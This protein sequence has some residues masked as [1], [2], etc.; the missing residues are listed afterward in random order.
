M[1]RRC[2][3]SRRSQRCRCRLSPPSRRP[4]MPSPPP[5]KMRAPCAP[6]KRSSN[7]SKPPMSYAPSATLSRR[8]HAVRQDIGGRSL[9]ALVV[10]S[11]PNIV[12]LTNFTG[13]SAIV[14]VAPDRLYFITD[15]RYLTAISESRGTAYECPDMEL[16]TVE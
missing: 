3:R 4:Q 10:T 2:P 1:R 15:F 6:W 9:D 8:H 13:S 11:L 12:Y 16:V 14:V 5:R 7:G